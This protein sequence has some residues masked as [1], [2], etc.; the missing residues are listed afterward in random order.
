M[1]TMQVEILADGTIKVTTDRIS[2]ANHMTA[3]A[4]MRNLAT[5]GG[6]AQKRTHKH[7]LIGAAVHAMQ[8]AIGKAH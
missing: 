1:D 6:G 5:A 4:L 3:E 8:H 7:G 2:Q